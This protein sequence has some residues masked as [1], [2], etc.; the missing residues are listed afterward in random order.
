M[1]ILFVCERLSYGGS[2]KML[3]NL[4]NHLTNEEFNISLLSYNGAKNHHL[5]YHK[6]LNLIHHSFN[7]NYTKWL[8][9]NIFYRLRCVRFIN[10]FLK[11]NH[12]DLIISFDDMVNINVLISK[13]HVKS[14]IIVSERSDPYH[15]KFYLK[16][17]KKLLY[18]KADA[19]VF[20]STFAR[21]FYSTIKDSKSYIIPN[22]ISDRYLQATLSL[23]KQNNIVSV[24]R[25]NLFQKRQ[26]LLIRA[27]KQIHEHHPNFKLILYGDGSDTEKIIEFIE[28]HGLKSKVIL[29]GVSNNIIDD[30]KDASLFVLSSKFE[31]IPNALLEAMALGI[32]VVTTDYSP[33]GVKEIIKN[34]ENG[35][36][37]KYDAVNELATAISY[38]LNNPSKA[39]QMALLGKKSVEKYNEKSIYKLWK[40]CFLEITKP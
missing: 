33:G 24:A 6:N 30:I 3:L 13:S 14:K 40:E 5:Q 38:M 21:K 12:Y 23:K 39:H 25:H 31:G 22:S 16:I 1:K 4:A 37:V 18:R 19:V 35:L 8:S 7:K 10:D 27:F 15:N 9:R 20:Q 28:S 34:N 32:P 36:V 11:D 2:S 29:A 26:D 17:I